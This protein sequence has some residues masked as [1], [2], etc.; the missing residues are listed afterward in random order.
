[1]TLKLKWVA[2]KL[3]DSDIDAGCIGLYYGRPADLKKN[4]CAAYTAEVSLRGTRYVL[5][6]RV[7]STAVVAKLKPTQLSKKDVLPLAEAMI[8]DEL[9]RLLSHFK[10]EPS[11]QPGVSEC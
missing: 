5:E 11:Q 2:E 4:P 1:M 6:V 10:D 9:K 8:Q 3:D 7:G